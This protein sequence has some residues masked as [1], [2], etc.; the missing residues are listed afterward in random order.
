[1]F[2]LYILNTLLPNCCYL[3]YTLFKLRFGLH[4]HWTHVLKFSAVKG[5]TGF[6]FYLINTSK[7]VCQL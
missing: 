1:V 3:R 4:N 2:T 5:V 7:N 6:I